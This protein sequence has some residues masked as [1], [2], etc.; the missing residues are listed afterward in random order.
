MSLK[1]IG[2]GYGRTGTRSTALALNALN[3]KCYHGFELLLN[4]DRRKHLDF[5]LKVADTPPGTQH[6]WETVF[7]HF[8][9]TVDMPAASVWR[10]LVEAYPDSKILLTLHPRGSAAWYN[11]IR[12][13]M[14]HGYNRWEFRAA[15]I[16]PF[17]RDYRRMLGVL[18]WQRAFKG[19]AA[20]RDQAIAAYEC[21]AAEVKAA[22]PPERLLVYSVDQGWRP[23]CTFLGVPVPSRPFPRA[24]RSLSTRFLIDA[25]AAGF[26][27]VLAIGA[28]AAAAAAYSLISW[29]GA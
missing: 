18:V 26:V 14:Y 1:V 28:A 3:L 24:N 15:S 19:K 20:D 6:D 25:A 11:S 22:V 9:A 5:W 27:L 13:T 16:I 23:L 29:L 21:L 8:A 4:P 12:K 17:M 2:I 7:S 10:E